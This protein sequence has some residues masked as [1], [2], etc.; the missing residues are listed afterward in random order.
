MVVNNLAD[1]L[2]LSGEESQTSQIYQLR[3]ERPITTHVAVQHQ[4]NIFGLKV[5]SLC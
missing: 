1:L 5:K 4:G 3:R 2:T